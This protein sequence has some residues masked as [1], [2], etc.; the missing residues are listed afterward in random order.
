MPIH[1]EYCT[2]CGNEI[3]VPFFSSPPVAPR[4]AKCTTVLNEARTYVDQ[5]CVGMEVQEIVLRLAV[6]SGSLL[7]AWL[8]GDA[9]AA[10]SFTA[11]SVALGERL[12]GM[13]E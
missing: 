13:F 3:T 10:E 12:L 5:V 2:R 9:K 6:S 7:N 8:T 4:C 1:V 11:M